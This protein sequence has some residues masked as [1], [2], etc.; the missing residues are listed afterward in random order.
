MDGRCRERTL[1]VAADLRMAAP[2]TWRVSQY[3]ADNAA[4]S[5]TMATMIASP[6]IGPVPTA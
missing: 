2:E 4:S 5:K 6:M 3:C 1:Q